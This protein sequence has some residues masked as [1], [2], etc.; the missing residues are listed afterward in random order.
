M[1]LSTIAKAD[2]FIFSP[3]IKKGVTAVFEIIDNSNACIDLKNSPCLTY[4]P[5]H[6]LGGS[7]RAFWRTQP[8]GSLQNGSISR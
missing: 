5:P 8:Y 3:M 6:G 7:V 4:F 2:I 1:R